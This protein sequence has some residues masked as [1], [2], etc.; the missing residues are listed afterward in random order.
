MTTPAKDEIQSAFTQLEAVFLTYKN[1]KASQ[2]NR[3]PLGD[4]NRV[5]ADLSEIEKAHLALLE[6]NLSAVIARQHLQ[7]ASAA[8]QSSD[9]LGRK[10]FW[11]NVVVAILTAV[12]A[13]SSVLSLTNHGA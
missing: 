7:A 12:M 1:G 6:S 3:Y 2:S 4:P 13:L 5:E 8:A 9:R 10:V 11:L